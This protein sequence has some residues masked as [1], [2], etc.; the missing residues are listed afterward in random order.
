MRGP[1]PRLRPCRAQMHNARTISAPGRTAGGRLK[2]MQ[3]EDAKFQ[4]GWP[5][6]AGDGGEPRDRAGGRA[7][8]GRGGCPCHRRRAQQRGGWRGVRSRARAGW[9]CDAVGG[10]C[11]RLRGGD[12]RHCAARAGPDPGQ[13]RGDEPPPADDGYPGRRS[14][15]H[16]RTQRQGR[17]LCRPRGGARAA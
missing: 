7:G 12:R 16:H 14:R 10:G 5:P 8:A 15:C 6:R 2:G 1:A 13:Q 4:G 3:C 9:A 11:H 17:L